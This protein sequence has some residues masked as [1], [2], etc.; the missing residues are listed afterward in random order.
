MIFYYL[1]LSAYGID[2]YSRFQRWTE[3]K[4]IQYNILDHVNMYF[5]R[6]SLW[7]IM[8]MAAV[9]FTLAISGEKINTAYKADRYTILNKDINFRMESLIRFYKSPAQQKPDSFFLLHSMSPFSR[10]VMLDSL[11]ARQDSMRHMASL[12]LSRIRKDTGAV[13]TD[14]M[15][16]PGNMNHTN[17]SLK[18]VMKRAEEEN[19]MVYAI[20][21]ASGRGFA[22]RSPGGYGGRRPG[23]DGPAGP[24]GAEFRQRAVP[25]ASLRDGGR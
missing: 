13:F 9:G 15:D 17:S 25:R 1:L 11:Q 21:L 23:G 16:S 22:R 3:N 19:V 18:D 20:G 4:N 24:R 7:A 6:T 2:K 10:L 5:Q 14:G 8:I 12:Y